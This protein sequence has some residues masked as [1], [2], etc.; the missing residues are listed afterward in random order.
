MADPTTLIDLAKAVAEEVNASGLL[1]DGVEASRVYVPRYEI[2]EQEG[3]SVQVV[4]NSDEEEDGSRGWVQN[5]LSVD[6][7]FVQK[8]FATDDVDEVIVLMKKVA[9]HLRATPLGSLAS[10]WLRNEMRPYSPELLRSNRVC[11]GV[12]TVTYRIMES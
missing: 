5:D 9:R 8:V 10:S 6:V 4:A 7:G 1:P 12:L 2:D 11:L 3:L